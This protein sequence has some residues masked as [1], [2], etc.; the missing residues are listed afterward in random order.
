MAAEPVR[1]GGGARRLGVRIAARPQRPDKERGAVRLL[2]ARP[3]DRHRPPGIVDE[4]LLAGIVTLAHRALQPL[5]PLTIPLAEGAVAQ[6]GAAVGGLIFLPQKMQRH[7]LVA[8]ELGVHPGAVRQH[9]AAPRGHR[10]HLPYPPLQLHLLESQRLLP[11]E[12]GGEHR[13]TVLRDHSLREIQ[14]LG[15]IARVQSAHLQLDELS[16][17]CGRDPRIRHRRRFLRGRAGADC[18]DPVRSFTSHLVTPAPPAHRLR[19]AR[20]CLAAASSLVTAN[21]PISSPAQ[22]LAPASSLVT[23][24][25]LAPVH[26]PDSPCARLGPGSRAAGRRSTADS[27]A[28][29]ASGFG[30]PACSPGDMRALNSISAANECADRRKTAPGS[31]GIDVV[32]FF[33]LGRVLPARIMP[34]D[35]LSSTPQSP[36]TRGPPMPASPAGAPPR[37]PVYDARELL[38]APPRCLIPYS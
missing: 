33:S 26:T 31:T 10:A 13:T 22:G 38:P 14:R 1:Q 6:G 35:R 19:Q 27:P 37:M 23:A 20:Q 8:L 36:R 4:Q 21:R 9:D 16:E 24:A 15:G 28:S 11:G 3:V 18:Y 25:S 12:A 17:R 2:A 30:S 29:P 34:R 5:R 7:M 32:L